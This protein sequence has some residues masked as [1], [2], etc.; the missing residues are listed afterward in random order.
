MATSDIPLDDTPDPAPFSPLGQGDRKPDL[1]VAQHDNGSAMPMG[2]TERDG[3]VSP[4]LGSNNEGVN[5]S[6]PATND[7]QSSHESPSDLMHEIR[8]LQSKLLLLEGK[9]GDGSGVAHNDSARSDGKR[10]SHIADE[11]QLRK[12][13]RRAQSARKWVE[14][15]ESLANETRDERV[16]Y[17]REGDYMH[18]I[19]PSGKG[20]HLIPGREGIGQGGTNFQSEREYNL[21]NDVPLEPRRG[22]RPLTSLRPHYS[23]KLGP[24]NEWDTSDSD[25]WSS[26]G[27]LKTRDFEYFRARLRGDFEWELDRLNAQKSRFEKYKKKKIIKAKREEEA[28]RKHDTAEA[29]VGEEERRD[30]SD[31]NLAIVASLNPLEWREFRVSRKTLAG[32]SSLIDILVGEPQVLDQLFDHYRT[33]EKATSHRSKAVEAHQTQKGENLAHTIASDGQAPLPERIRIHSNELIKTLRIIHGSAI[34]SGDITTGSLVMLRPYRMLTYYESE[35][36]QWHSRLEKKFRKSKSLTVE[37]AATDKSMAVVGEEAADDEKDDEKSTQE[38]ASDNPDPEGYSK[39]ETALEHLTCLLEFMD[40]YILKRQEFLKSSACEKIFF[41]DL[42]HL[43][44]PGDL[45]ISA[46]G[47]QAYQVFNVISHPHVG[48]DRWS[49]FTRDMGN[50]SDESIEDDISVQCVF[51]H[52]DGQQVGPVL[53]TFSIPKFDGEKPVTSLS[54][55]PLRFHVRKKLDRQI[56]KLKQ[57]EEQVDEAVNHGVTELQEALVERGKLFTEVSA[58]KHMY[59]S[60]LTVD[61]RDEVQSQVMIDFAEA[62]MVEKNKDWKPDLKQLIGFIGTEDSSHEAPCNALCCTNETVHNDVYVDKKRHHNFMKVMMSRVEDGMDDLPPANIYPRP[63]ETV[64]TGEGKLRRDDLLIMSYSVFGFVLRDRSWAQLDLAHLS[65]VTDSVDDSVAISDDDTEDDKTAFGQL[66]L[67]PGHKKMVLSLI[68]QHF[69]NKAMQRERQRD[70]QVDIVRGK[71]KGLIILLHGAP[72]VGKTTTAEGV[73]EKFKK[74]LFQITCGDLGSTAKDVEDALQTNF[75]LANRWGCILLLDEADVFLAERRRDDF[76]RNGLVAVFLRVLEYYA[77]ILFL[78]TNR[79]GDFDE[80]F[81]S[82]IHMSLHYPPLELLSTSKIFELNL[83]MIKTRYQDAG[84]KIKIDKDEIVRYAVDYWQRN[85]KARLNGRQIRNACQT[86]LAL[87]EFD[88]QPEGSK[89]DLAVTSDAKVHLS[90]NNIQTVSEAYLEFIEYLK[91]V[92]GTDAE[93]HANEAGLR[94]LETAYLAMKSGGSHRGKSSGQAPKGRQSPLE[95][96]KLQSP[97]PRAQTTEMR[98]EQDYHSQQHRRGPSYDASQ[99]SVA[100]YNTPPRMSHPQSGM[101]PYGQGM[102]MTGQNYL[103][104]QDP[105]PGQEQFNPPGSQQRLPLPQHRSYS[106]S[107]PGTGPQY[108]PSSGTHI[109]DG[110]SSSAMGSMHERSADAYGRQ[111]PRTGNAWPNVR[112]Q[113]PGNDMPQQFTDH[114]QPYPRAGNPT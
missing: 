60:G 71:G 85:D 42:W 2:P 96:F 64:K 11:R 52:F 112:G 22:I 4:D 100:P 36:R 78:T 62:F 94:A 75:A 98:P 92:H 105:A 28:N 63:L 3:P 79:I 13:I 55:Y 31:K 107:P 6:A 15:A 9:V 16:D 95:T 111:D 38:E 61:T 1:P 93:T 106:P 17:G 19:L 53:R 12:Q 69:R 10:F 26:D 40:K 30:E 70:E 83:Q 25:E 35:I 89:Y 72:G 46:D 114:N 82:R 84:R 74:P 87:A 97:P 49:K 27:S 68:S 23:R 8:A 45:V 104:Y 34:S 90:V 101:P 88:A 37:D 33:K 113:Q 99:S 67:P 102:S 39:S 21:W 81:A 73:A 20:S 32:S 29:K 103:Q 59:Y 65:H 58:V 43:F 47:K 5:S 7:R 110:A 77:G 50:S 24:P 48:T 41:S 109:A 86:A 18:W 44:K 91:A 56:M 57:S 108:R 80:A 54:I 66:V 76:T 51:I 14:E